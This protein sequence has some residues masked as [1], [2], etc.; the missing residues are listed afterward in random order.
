MRNI[1]L[2][3]MYDGSDF[4]G[5]Q[6]QP[7]KR[8]VQGVLEGS[9]LKIIKEE[10]NLIS[11]GRTDRGVHAQMQ[12]S[13]FCT[14]SSIPCERLMLALNNMLPVDI[15]IIS[16]EEAEIDFNSRYNAK[17]RIYRY[18]LTNLKSPFHNRFSTFLER[19]VE[20][21]KFLEILQP[22]VG[23][24]DFRNFRLSDCTS[25]HQVREIYSITG[26]FVNEHEFYIEIRGNAFL[27]SQ[28]R[29]IIGTA[30]EIYFGKK[31]Q[32]YFLTLL[33]DFQK[34]HSKIVAPP[35]GLILYSIKY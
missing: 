18:Y 30:L 23:R 21:F 6:K 25:K 29:I 9:I 10:I 20:L 7:L 35:N 16:C 17:E 1:K 27:K 14:H 12:I 3:Y 5:F 32:D 33:H 22:L 24:H 13:N 2:T 8:T 26:N 19:P 31:S 4:L 11:S 15:S 34:D 28:I